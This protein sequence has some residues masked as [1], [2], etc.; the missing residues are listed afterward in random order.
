MKTYYLD[1]ESLY[2]YLSLFFKVMALVTGSCFILFCFKEELKRVN[3]LS[4]LSLLVEF[5]S[6][7]K[8][9]H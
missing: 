9:F 3:T 5:L 7:Q 1:S 8:Y 2:C 6:I 4:V